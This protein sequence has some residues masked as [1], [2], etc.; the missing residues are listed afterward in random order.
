M[1]KSLVLILGLIITLSSISACQYTINNPFEKGVLGFYEDNI[2]LE[3]NALEAKEFADGARSG[4]FGTCTYPN[5]KVYNNY[6]SEVNVTIKYNFKGQQFTQDSVIASKGYVLVQNSA[7]GESGLDSSSVSYEIH[8]PIN[9]K[10]ETRLI[11]FDNITCKICPDGRECLDDGASCNSNDDCGSLICNINKICGK[12]GSIFLVPCLDGTLNCNNQSC[13]VPAV[14]NNEQA[15]SCSWECGSGMIACNGVCRKINAKNLSEEYHCKEECI[16]QAGDGKIC[17]K[18]EEQLITEADA[19]RKGW[20]IFLAVSSIIAA[21]L[22]WYFAFHKRGQALRDKEKAEEER[23]K[24]KKE[25]EDIKK[26][27][28]VLKKDKDKIKKDIE[29]ATK[30]SEAKIKEI[31]ERETLEIKELQEKKKN[32]TSEAKRVIDEEISRIRLDKAQDIEKAKN[33]RDSELEKYKL[34]LED[35]KSREKDIG[36]AKKSMND[37]LPNPQGY[38]VTIND[39]GYQI[40]GWGEKKL[41]HI[42]WYEKNSED[43]VDSKLFEVHHIDGDKRNNDYS[44]LIKIEKSI[45]YS[46][47]RFNRPWLS[48]E[49]GIEL[50]KK[51]GVELPDRIK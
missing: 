37:P 9:L 50:L 42:W 19:R 21:F 3:Y 51:Y 15:Y 26:D 11:E 8:T 46:I 17:V 39:E 47:H 34:E 30:K 14:K 45:H 48:R 49:K 13:L 24:A 40:C 2:K 1:N 6:T 18:N 29:K 32:A 20:I 31:N 38:K 33:E 16:S 10:W 28:E 43:K 7:C 5:F 36:I 25:N 41:F 22:I 12:M 44:N 23:D 4:F 35:L 27:L